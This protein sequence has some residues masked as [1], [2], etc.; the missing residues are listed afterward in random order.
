[1]ELL[2]VREVFVECFVGSWQ[3]AE[4]ARGGTL[5]TTTPSVLFYTQ[6]VT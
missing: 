4:G 6:W 2:E 1:M 3:L 5:Y